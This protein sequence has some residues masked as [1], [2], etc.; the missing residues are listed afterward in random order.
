[1]SA[2]VL[3]GKNVEGIRTGRIPDPTVSQVVALAAAFGVPPSYL[4]DRGTDPS[5]LDEEGLEALSD[6]TASAI[7]REG[8]R[9]PEREKGIVLKIVR[10]VADPTDA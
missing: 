3:T 8:A 10:Q 5:V 1:M 6:E 9:L 2:G 7:L 4:M